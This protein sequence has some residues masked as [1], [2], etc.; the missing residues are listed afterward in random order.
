MVSEPTMYLDQGITV[1]GSGFNPWEPII[2][3]IDLGEP[4]ESFAGGWGAATFNPSLGQVD[5]NSSG[6]WT[7]TVEG[8][9]TDIGGVS[10]N[11]ARL[12][13][14][15]VITILAEGQDGSKASWPVGVMAETPPPEAPGPSIATSLIV[16]GL[17]EE[18][19]E[20]MVYGAGFKAKERLSLV[21]IT[22]IGKGTSYAPQ[23]VEYGF[24]DKGTI[25]PSGVFERQGVT[26]GVAEETGAFMISISPSGGPGAYTLEAFGVDGSYA[27][28]PLIIVP[29]K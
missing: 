29:P 17:V 7:L 20:V 28:A 6:A 14:A 26:L 27:T 23:G 13:D 19:G 9:L 12:L 18:G 2:V 11:M 15:G 8:P 3:T 25:A 4:L 21:T 24:Y 16:A 10:K 1:A 5:S 22:G